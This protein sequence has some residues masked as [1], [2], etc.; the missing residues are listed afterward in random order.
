M[1]DIN[2]QELFGTISVLLGLVSFS[3]YLRSILQGKTRPHL[4]TW[5][6]WTTLTWIAFIIQVY[7]GAGPGA[8]AVGLTAVTTTINFLFAI[9][10]GDRDYKRSDWVSLI[11][12]LASIPLWI[13]TKDPT[14]ST[15]LVTMICAIAF[16]PTI[17]KSWVKPNLES[18]GAHSINLG[19][20]ALTVM[21]V[22]T[23]NIATTFFPAVLLIMNVILVTVIYVRRRQV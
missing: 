2:Y 11:V 16:Y 13:I 22:Q 17:R 3:I 19:K 7:A 23:Y 9:R 10:N 21:A 5:V 14:A 1:L 8:W 6:L 20:H 15:I 4:F 12:G 18:L